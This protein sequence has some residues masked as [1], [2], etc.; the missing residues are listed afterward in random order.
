MS[1]SDIVYN[2]RHAVYAKKVREAIA[3]AIEEISKKEDKNLEIY[4][5][6]VIGA[7][8]SNA[9]IV[10]AR[11]D[12]NTGKRYEKVGK[13]LDDFSSQIADIESLKATK[14]E[15]EVERNRITNLATLQ[16]GSTTGDAELAD[17]R[18]AADGKT[19]KNIGGAIRGQVGEL[20]E[21]LGNLGTNNT[22]IVEMNVICNEI[23]QQSSSSYQKW[24][25]N[26]DISKLKKGD[27]IY[28]MI[29][30]GYNLL[31]TEKYGHPYLTYS[32]GAVIHLPDVTELNKWYSFTLANDIT[33]LGWRL[34][35]GYEGTTYEGTNS[36]WDIIIIKDKPSLYNFKEID[37]IEKTKKATRIFRAPFYHSIQDIGAYIET[38][39]KSKIDTWT[40]IGVDGFS[41]NIALKWDGTALTTNVT[42]EMLINICNYIIS[43]GLVVFAWKFGC[44]TY[45]SS[46]E[47]KTAYETELLRFANLLKSNASTLK[48][49]NIII[50][51]ECK[52][53]LDTTNANWAVQ[54]I[55]N[56]RNVGLSVGISY[57]LEMFGI[58]RVPNSVV[59][60]L[61]FLCF[62]YYPAIGNKGKST[63]YDDCLVAWKESRILKAIKTY[64]YFY[65]NKKIFIS[66]TGIGDYYNQY[67]NPSQWSLAGTGEA[68]NGITQ[69][70]YLRAMMETVNGSISGVCSWYGIEKEN[71][72]SVLK[73]YLGKVE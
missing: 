29:K 17:G 3:S 68:S 56:I 51:N 44:T 4:N 72:V 28:Y 35:R 21:T 19:Y 16:E 14:Q 5:N 66:E 70:N 1:L 15:V 2:I 60:N 37:E 55:T 31:N 45:D 71:T 24:V 18:V 58:G 25:D 67:G 53:L 38:D 69:G 62:N 9:E 50:F 63:T 57:D 13:R 59:L 73:K 64:K 10:D 52:L 34:Y 48:C 27:T 33:Q 8:E 6:M 30:S 47:F 43:K 42:D 54:V 49:Y 23:A 40:D 12:N 36:K 65:P 7:G 41:I 26:V 11:L 32:T 46:S 61:G 22:R 20:K 39:L